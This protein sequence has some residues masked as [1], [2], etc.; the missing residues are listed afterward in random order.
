MPSSQ[1]WTCSAGV[2]VGRE[3]VEA[4]EEVDM[5][6]GEVKGEVEEDGEEEG[7]EGEEGDS[8]TTTTRFCSNVVPYTFTYAYVIV[9]KV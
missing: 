9:S 3:M 1:A 4:E 2:I 8:V 5:V 7:E 6:V